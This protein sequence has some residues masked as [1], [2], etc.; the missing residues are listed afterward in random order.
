MRENDLVGLWE[1]IDFRFVVEVFGKD[2]FLIWMGNKNH[3][4]YEK[5]HEIK[6][7]KFYVKTDFLLWILFP[8]TATLMLTIH[9]N[10]AG[11]IIATV[12]TL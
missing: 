8:W 6:C 9:C 12:K 11:Y 4:K 3:F 1:T 5:Q 2:F 10:E 7:Y